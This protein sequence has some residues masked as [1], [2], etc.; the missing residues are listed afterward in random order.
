MKKSTIDFLNVF[1]YE[2]FVL[3]NQGEN[4]ENFEVKA[5]KAIFVGYAAGKSY[6]FYNLRDNIIMESMHIIFNDKRI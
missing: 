4:L 1:G 5:D 2:C 6:K 3:R